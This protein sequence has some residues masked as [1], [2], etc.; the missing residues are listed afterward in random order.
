MW[1]GCLTRVSWVVLSIKK[2]VSLV[3]FFIVHTAS[4]TAE[5]RYVLKQ[6][7]E[8]VMNAKWKLLN[9]LGAQMHD[10]A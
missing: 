2:T 7:Q 9:M 8:V 10:S 5:T 3:L 6:L 1:E 4:N